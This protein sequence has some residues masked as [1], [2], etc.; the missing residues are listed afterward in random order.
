MKILYI[1][2]RTINN[3]KQSYLPLC[4]N[5]F[6][7]APLIRAP[8]IIEAWLYWSLIINESLT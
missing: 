2:L 8:M 3:H 1:V 7:D 6:V 5:T 4:L